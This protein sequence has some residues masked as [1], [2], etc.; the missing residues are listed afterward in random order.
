MRLS[1]KP[2]SRPLKNHDYFWVFSPIVA[3]DELGELC[4]SI[5]KCVKGYRC[6][7]KTKFD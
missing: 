7:S 4:I 5:R 6:F 2:L 3:S 1:V